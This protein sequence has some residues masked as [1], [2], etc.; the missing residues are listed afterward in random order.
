VGPDAFLLFLSSESFSCV[1]KLFS[2]ME[3]KGWIPPS[4]LGPKKPKIFMELKKI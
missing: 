2:L 1:T 4:C 3:S